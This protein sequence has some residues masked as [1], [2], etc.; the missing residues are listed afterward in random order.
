MNACGPEINPRGPKR[1]R[2][3]SLLNSGVRELKTRFTAV[4]LVGFEELM[5]PNGVE[6]LRLHAIFLQRHQS[7]FFFFPPEQF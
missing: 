2:T 3:A 5:G 7:P 6:S 1:K 4:D